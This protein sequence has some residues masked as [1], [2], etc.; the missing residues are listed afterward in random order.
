M[1]IAVLEKQTRHPGG[2][3][4]LEYSEVFLLWRIEEVFYIGDKGGELHREPR[5]E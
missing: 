4:A 2:I 3:Q 5:Q 1:H